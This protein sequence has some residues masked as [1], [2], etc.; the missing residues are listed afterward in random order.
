L[1]FI[2]EYLHLWYMFAQV[3]ITVMLATMNYVV[4]KHC[5]FARSG[6]APVD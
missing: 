2:V 4:F 6:T 1:L 5:I 3:V